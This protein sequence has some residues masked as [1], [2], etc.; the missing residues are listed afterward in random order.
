VVGAQVTTTSR[1]R[2]FDVFYVQEQGGRPFGWSDSY[3]QDRLRDS[4]QHAAEHG[5]SENDAPGDPQ[6]PAPTRSRLHRH[7]LG[8]S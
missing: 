1:R 4:V 2:A 8:Q 7:A 3:I 6:T 5:L